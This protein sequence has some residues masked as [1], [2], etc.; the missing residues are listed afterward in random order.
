MRGGA[1]KLVSMYPQ[2]T[3]TSFNM[4]RR[5]NRRLEG[6]LRSKHN[7]LTQRWANAGPAS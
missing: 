4:R 6:E 2:Y 5:G 1:L 7:T 3:K